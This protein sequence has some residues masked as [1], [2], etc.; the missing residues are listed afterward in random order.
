MLLLSSSHSALFS[1]RT[2]QYSTHNHQHKA[3]SYS[4]IRSVA[5]TITATAAL[6]VPLLLLS[7]CGVG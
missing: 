1:Q 5:A 2:F 6:L 3:L 4:A 7:Y